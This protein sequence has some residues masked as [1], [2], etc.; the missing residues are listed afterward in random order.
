[1]A[2]LASDAQHLQRD[3]LM[4]PAPES[5]GLP[6]PLVTYFSGRDGFSS[7]LQTLSA[8]ITAI[9]E[10]NSYRSNLLTVTHEIAHILVQVLLTHIYPDLSQSQGLETAQAIAQ[11]HFRAKNWLMAARQLLLEGIIGMEQADSGREIPMEDL[12]EDLPQILKHQRREAQEIIVHT[13][14]FWYFYRGEPEFYIKSIWHSWCAILGIEDRVPEYLMRTLCAVS[15]TLLREPAE[16]RFPAALHD[17]KG[18]L[19]GLQEQ[20]GVL[21]D[22]ISIALERIARIEEDKDVRDD[23]ERQYSTR[24]LLVRLVAIFLASERLSA[25]LYSDPHVGK[26]RGYENK[27]TL[28]YDQEPIGNPLTFFRVHLKDDPGESESLWVLH[29]LAFDMVA[30]NDPV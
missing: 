28:A 15:V 13:L 27:Q 10:C 22:Y 8:P 14:D 18:I 2:D 21:S 9:A 20:G 30:D 26:G 6:V 1:M 3:L 29:C 19:K 17:V 24:L 12:P 23:F 25:K 11:K 5:E 4:R 7:H 16:K